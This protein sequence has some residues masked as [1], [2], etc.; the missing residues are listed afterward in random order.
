MIRFISCW[1][2]E[3]G[4]SDVSFEG[5]CVDDCYY[6]YIGWCSLLDV[7]S[8]KGV[9]FFLGSVWLLS[10]G[11]RMVTNFLYMPGSVMPTPT[12]YVFDWWFD[13]LPMVIFGSIMFCYSFVNVW[14]DVNG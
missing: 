10:V 13:W 1:R 8:M 4:W 3:R 12:P 7:G 2:L 6:Y 14:R 9:V 5:Y 11:F